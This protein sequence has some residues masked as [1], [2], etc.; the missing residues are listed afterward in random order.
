MSVAAAYPR[1]PWSDALVDQ[2]SA[3]D[4]RDAY[5]ADQVRTYIAF[6]IRAL[7]EQSSRNWSQAELAKRCGT[8]QSAISRAEDPDY[9]KLTLQTLLEIASA[10]DLPLLIQFVEWEDWLRRM[11]DVSPPALQKRGFNRERLMAKATWSQAPT[12]QQRVVSTRSGSSSM[13]GVSLPQGTMGAAMGGPHSRQERGA[14]FLA[15]SLA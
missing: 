3:K 13:G 8:T 12:T 2:L 1:S 11:A 4:F 15:S 7:R 14:Q 6:Q 5:A 10:Y 9:G